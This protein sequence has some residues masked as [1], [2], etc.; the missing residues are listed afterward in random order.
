MNLRVVRARDVLDHG[1]CEEFLESTSKVEWL[2]EMIC[3]AGSQSETR[4]AALLVLI[5]TIENST[6]PKLLANHVK[7]LAFTRCGELK[8]GSRVN[9][10]HLACKGRG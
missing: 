3:Q 9:V 4:S 5:S 8:R 6:E 10:N 7:Y 1:S 2:D